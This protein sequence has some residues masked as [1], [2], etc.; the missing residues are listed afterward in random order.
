MYGSIPTKGLKIHIQT[1]YNKHFTVLTPLSDHQL[2]AFCE[3]IESAVYEIVQIPEMTEICDRIRRQNRGKI[4]SIKLLIY[5]IKLMSVH[6]TLCKLPV[7][8]KRKIITKSLDSDR[9]KRGI[10]AN[11]IH[12]IE[13]L[14]TH[15]IISTV[16]DCIIT[17]HDAFIFDKSKFN[18]QDFHKLYADM[19]L[20]VCSNFQ[21]FS[22]LKNPYS[23]DI[24]R[25][26]YEEY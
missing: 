15:K 3:A 18:E 26:I 19:L 13:S 20:D 24:E 7:I 11:F 2:N 22:S 21:V 25:F 10:L 5:Q 23:M 16:P 6:L 8:V 14:V 17:I 1:M 4:N 12:S 9:M